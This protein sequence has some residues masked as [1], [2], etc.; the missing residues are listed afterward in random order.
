[1]TFL[2][3]TYFVIGFITS[4]FVYDYFCKNYKESSEPS[5]TWEEYCSDN[6]TI[7]NDEYAII[8]F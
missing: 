5:L 8:E 3:L 4:Y 1:M 6:A 7:Y 2:I